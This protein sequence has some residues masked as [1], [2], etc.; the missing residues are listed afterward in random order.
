M[1]RFAASITIQNVLMEDVRACQWEEYMEP[2]SGSYQ[3]AGVATNHG[4]G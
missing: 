4:S 1:F 2:N 3:L